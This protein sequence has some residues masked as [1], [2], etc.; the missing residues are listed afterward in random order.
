MG[1]HDLYAEARALRYIL[2]DLR[3]VVEHAADKRRH[4]LAWIVALEPRR[5]V[6][7]KRIGCGMG[8]I[9]RIGREGRHIVED[10]IGGLFVYSALHRA[11]ALNRAVLVDKSVYEI[12]ALALHDVVLLF[13]HGAADYI[14]PA[15]GV[16]RKGAE[17]L[18]NL[19]LIYHT[20]VSDLEYALEHRGLV[21][22]F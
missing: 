20:A 3:R 4:E 14:R 1:R 10:I 5:F 22:Y 21:A 12:M 11:L 17:Y 13:R 9:E 15:V 7:D 2:R 6:G 16:A 8:L 18:H 19:L